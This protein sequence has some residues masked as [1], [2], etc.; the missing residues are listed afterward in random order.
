[1]AQIPKHS[2]EWRVDIQALRG[3]AVTLVVLD[4]IKFPYLRGGFLGVDIFFVISGFLMTGLIVDGIDRKDFTL[5]GFYARRI[6]RL[7]PA[8]YATIIVTALLAPFLLDPYEVRN[9]LTQVAGAFSFSANFVLWQQ[10]DYFDSD[11][12]FKP[13]LHLWSLAVEEQ[14]YIVIPFL[15]LL[16]PRRLRLAV[17]S[18]LVAGSLTACLYFVSRSP[19][20][21]FYLL[22]FRAWELGLGSVAALIVRRWGVVQLGG[23]FLRLICAGLLLAIPIVCDQSGHPGL[24][25]LAVCLLTAWLMMSGKPQARAGFLSPMTFIGDR[26]YTL[27]LVHWPVLAFAHNVYLGK[28]PP[29]VIAGLMLVVLVWMELQY[30]LVEQRFRSLKITAKSLSV[31]IILPLVTLGL[32]YLWSYRIDKF[33]PTDRKG[34]AG[35]ASECSFKGNYY[36]AFKTCQSAAAPQTLLWGDSFAMHLANGLEATTPTGITQ[37]TRTTCGPF[38]GLAPM[39]EMQNPRPWAQDCIHFND[40]VIAYLKAHPEI[41][42]VVLSSVLRQYVPKGEALNWQALIETQGHYRS[43]WP[44]NAALLQS[45]SQTVTTLHSMGKRVVLIAPPPSVDFDIGLCLSRSVSGR[46]TLSAHP[47]CRFSVAEYQAQRKPVLDFLS[48]VEKQGIVEII[49]FEPY[50]CASGR[51]QTRLKGTPLYRDVSH[52]SISGSKRIGEEMHLGQLVAE[53]AR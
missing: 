6:R 26:S 42:T 33:D 9:F 10:V 21:A 29:E 13:L 3:L 41:H 38:L 37:A 32:L 30:R 46:P 12:G 11:S 49:R 39:N 43:A 20:A 44:D 16:C 34:N 24:S 31:F 23:P 19:S 36:T 4:H 15:L 45:L 8:A 2:S 48:Q 52:F 25:A 47:D 50:L 22:P 53:R 1:M 7:L 51:C 28:V 27:Y 40:S 5:R 17:G 18:L 35:L 14:Y